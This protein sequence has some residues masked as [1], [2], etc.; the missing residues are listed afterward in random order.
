MFVLQL[1]RAWI[2]RMF[3]AIENFDFK[4]QRSM[5]CSWMAIYDLSSV[6]EMVVYETET[7]V[8]QI[9]PSL[10]QNMW[11]NTRVDN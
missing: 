4:N 1:E 6:R 3:Y 8:T 2:S 11:S 5:I 10:H 9:S 7:F